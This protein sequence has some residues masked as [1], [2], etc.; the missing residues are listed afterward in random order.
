MTGRSVRRE[1]DGG[2]FASNDEECAS[3]N[4]DSTIPW[5]ASWLLPYRERRGWVRHLWTDVLKAALD[6]VVDLL[7]GPHR[8]VLELL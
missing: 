8:P 7:A 5:G 1:F 2:E 3:A 4:R 6:A